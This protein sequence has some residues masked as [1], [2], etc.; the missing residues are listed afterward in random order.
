MLQN[1]RIRASSPGLETWSDFPFLFSDCKLKCVGFHG[2]SLE[3]SLEDLLLCEVAFCSNWAED[4]NTGKRRASFAFL[5]ASG[6]PKSL[7][8]LTQ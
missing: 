8:I 1:N 4:A 6:N 7:A 3:V 2:A 5:A